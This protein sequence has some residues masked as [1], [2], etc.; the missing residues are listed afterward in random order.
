MPVSLLGRGAAWAFGFQL[1]QAA[2]SLGGPELEL[3]FDWMLYFCRQ[4]DRLA[5]WAG[6]HQGWQGPTLEFEC[7]PC[8]KKSLGL[9]GAWPGSPG[10]P[11]CS[12]DLPPREGPPWKRLPPSSLLVP[13]CFLFSMAACGG[14][15]G[16]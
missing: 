9:E 6:G 1:A 2:M 15:G 7:P 4:V 5:P 12:E 13:T 8:P 16:L 11:L 10:T 14:G 3:Y